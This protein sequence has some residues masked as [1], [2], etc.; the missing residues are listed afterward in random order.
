MPRRYSL[1]INRKQIRCHVC[2]NYYKKGTRTEHLKTLKHR[3]IRNI[4]F[5]TGLFIIPIS[6]K[7]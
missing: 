3:L 7:L 2:K 5:E 4:T 1:Y 6:I